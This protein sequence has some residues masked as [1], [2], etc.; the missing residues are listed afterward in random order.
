M[1][2]PFLNADKEGFDKIFIHP[3]YDLMSKTK[4]EINNDQKTKILFLVYL[5]KAYIDIKL[6]T[7]CFR[8]LNT[9]E[10]EYN[11]NGYIHFPKI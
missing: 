2:Y 9:I 3:L 11:I 7:D 6:F 10:I 5:S 8:G 4:N 1:N